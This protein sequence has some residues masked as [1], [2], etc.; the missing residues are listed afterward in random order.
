MNNHNYSHLHL[1]LSFQ[2][3]NMVDLPLSGQ[4]LSALV[5][6]KPVASDSTANFIITP[7][8]CRETTYSY[9]YSNKK[10]TKNLRLNICSSSYI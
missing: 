2:L 10:A 6:E 1:Y 3:Q 5:K 4:Y 7:E 8:L 9:N